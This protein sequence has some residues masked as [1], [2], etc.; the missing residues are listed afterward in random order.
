MR[1]RLIRK[2]KIV[3]LETP[4]SASAMVESLEALRQQDDDWYLVLTDKKDD[5][6]IQPLQRGRRGPSQPKR[7]WK[8][9]LRTIESCTLHRQ[10]ISP[11]LLPIVEVS[12]FTILMKRKQ[13]LRG[14]EMLAHFIHRV[15]HGSLNS[16]R[17]SLCSRLPTLSVKLWRKQI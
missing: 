2:V 6:Y 9:K 12:S 17:E 5:E 3:G 15:L 13:L 11:F 8:Q 14:L 1:M 7:S 4:E 16:L 10:Q